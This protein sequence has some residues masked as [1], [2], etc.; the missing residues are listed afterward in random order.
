M[1][2]FFALA[3]LDRQPDLVFPRSGVFRDGKTLDMGEALA[4]L[5]RLNDA[6]RAHMASSSVL[7]NHLFPR[8]HHF[9]FHLQTLE[10]VW[11]IVDH[12]NPLQKGLAPAKSIARIELGDD[13]AVKG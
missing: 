9:D 2:D 5:E 13:G 8:T 7:V 12:Q 6:V 4:G 11:K 3:V 1:P 10:A